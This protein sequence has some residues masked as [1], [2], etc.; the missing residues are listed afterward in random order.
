MDELRKLQQVS[1][2]T[3]TVSIPSEY[4]KHLG[5]KKGGNIVVKEEVD[6][7]LRLIPTARKPKTAKASIRVDVVGMAELLSRLVVSCYML[8][9]DAI[10]LTSKAGMSPAYLAE[11]NKT[12]RRLRGVEIVQSSEHVIL[13][14]S[15][16]DPAKFPVDSLIKRLQLLVSKSLENSIVALRNGS[17]SVLNEIRKIQGEIDELYWLIVRQLLVALSDR[18][19]S[20]K[21]GLESPL[22]T[23]G[24]RVSAKTIEEIG[25]II[26]ELTEET[27]NSREAG[28]R[29]EER[30][31]KRIEDLAKSASDCFDATIESLLVPEIGTIDRALAK[32]EATLSLERE[33]TLSWR[34]TAT[35]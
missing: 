22:H 21:I 8:G 14:Q 28:I 26:L 18:E 35:S 30:T 12:L 4:V 17:P 27:V 24:D 15:F 13:A 34:A 25:Q 2:S 6:G 32:I 11:T 16:M 20:V 29:I 7:T 33:V 10:E 31:M 9:Y 19:I 1:N 23:S 3:L 5:L